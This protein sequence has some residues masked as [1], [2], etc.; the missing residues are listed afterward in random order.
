MDNTAS[1][2]AFTVAQV[3]ARLNI[4]RDSVYRAINEGKLPAKKLGKRTLIVA[5]D[6][7][8]FLKSLPQ[9]G[10]GVA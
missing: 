3:M 5:A 9:M 4:G 8:K 7:E 6:L 2:S 1:T 10:G